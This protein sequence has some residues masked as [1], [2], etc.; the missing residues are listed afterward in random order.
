MAHEKDNDTLITNEDTLVRR[1]WIE[2]A[3]EG[4]RARV[5]TSLSHAEVDAL[6]REEFPA[7]IATCREDAEDADRPELYLVWDADERRSGT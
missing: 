2:S 4:V 5:E 1:A 3:V 7:D 6:V